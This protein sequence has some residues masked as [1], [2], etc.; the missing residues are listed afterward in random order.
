M[1]N[2]VVDVGAHHSEIP[3]FVHSGGLLLDLSS[4]G[5]VL[6]VCLVAWFLERGK[7]DWPND[8]LDSLEEVRVLLASPE[9]VNHI[10]DTD[11]AM[12]AQQLL[13]ENVV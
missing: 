4:S 7:L 3:T 12:L 2:E 11:A 10:L 9:R 6:G 5:I 13:D 8:F 1:G